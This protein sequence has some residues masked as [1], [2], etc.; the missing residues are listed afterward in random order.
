MSV[1]NFASDFWLA[2]DLFASFRS[3]YILFAIPI[4]LLAL[5]KRY[6]FGVLGSSAVLLINLVLVAPSYLRENGSATTG[7]ASPAAHVRILHVNA[8][9]ENQQIAAV[10]DVVRDSDAD[11]VVV[12]EV[13]DSMRKR[14]LE[15]D[16][17][18][19]MLEA[20]ETAML[21]RRGPLGPELI[22]W[23]AVVL[24]DRPC[25]EAHLL[26]KG[27][28]L[29][30]LA[31]HAWAPLTFARLRAQEEQF[32]SIGAWYRR[33]RTSAVVVGDLNATPWSAAF[34]SL[35][36]STDLV[37][38]RNGFG[39]HATWPVRPLPMVARLMRIPIDHCLH[40][41]ALQTTFRSVGPDCG[42]NH[43]PV[44][45]TLGWRHLP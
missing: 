45:V 14:L 39:I 38:S 6:L 17:A 26:T 41:P 10:A 29:A 42:S 40:S 7:A 12:Q 23:Q 24:Q 4:L 25:I 8:W 13:V 5:W 1:A 16:D 21:I 9:K 27:G 36:R 43:L 22:S 19:T 20:G 2:L 15:L 37:D 35:L 34:R 28:E 3:Q 33:Q 31:I 18:F 44:Y 32:K 30:I 11:V